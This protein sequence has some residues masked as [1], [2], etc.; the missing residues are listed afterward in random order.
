[1][2]SLEIALKSKHCTGCRQ[3]VDLTHLGGRDARCPVCG[4]TYEVMLPETTPHRVVAG[5][6]PVRRAA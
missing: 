1:M 6:C 5:R 2:S 4:R 3:T